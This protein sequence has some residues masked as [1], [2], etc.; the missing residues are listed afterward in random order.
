[1]NTA[2]LARSAKQAGVKVALC[3]F[4]FPDVDHLGRKERYFFD[5]EIERTWPGVITLEGYV[6]LVSV[7]NAMLQ[8]LCEQEGYLYVPVAENLKGGASLFTD[9]CH[10]NPAGIERKADI[11]AIQL[12]DF[13][14]LRP[15]APD[16]VTQASP[17][18]SHPPR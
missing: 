9:I 2:T 13:V 16:I 8:R 17:P 1:V 11:I 10:M 3:S 14:A 5:A 4:A 12:K 6:R 15:A 7:Y 18:A